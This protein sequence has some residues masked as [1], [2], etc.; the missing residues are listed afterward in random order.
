VGD[1]FKALL[2]DMARMA[3]R[4][5][6]LEPLARSF[7]NA[8][9]SIGD[10]NA[11]TGF[12]GGLFSL[13]NGFS[14]IGRTG[15]TND[16][17]LFPF[18]LSFRFPFFRLPGR[19]NGGPVKA[20][21]LYRVNEIGMEVFQPA[22]DGIILNARQ[23][24]V[25]LPGGGGGGPTYVINAQGATPDVVPLIRQVLQQ[26]IPNIQRAGVSETMR[27]A[28]RAALPGRRS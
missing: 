13:G 20:G 10:G 16:G 22:V 14:G 1:V 12:F 11:S 5:A 26:Q 6:V 3:L 23:T 8:F 4:F 9:A 7:S 25:P 19:A 18:P 24:R 28:T 2:Q 27:Q 15:E 17:A 21:N